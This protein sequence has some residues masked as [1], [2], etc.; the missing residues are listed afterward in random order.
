MARSAPRPE[1]TEFIDIETVG[2]S[3]P[4]C[5]HRTRAAYTCTRKVTMLDGVVQLCLHVRRCKH[6]KCPLKGRP[7]RPEAEGSFALPVHEFGLQVMAHVGALRYTQHRSVPEIHADLFERGVVISERSVTNL[8]DRYDE[9]LALQLGSDA[10][11]QEVTSKLG[12]VVLALDG[13]Q[14]DVGHEVLWVVR[15]ILS[16]EILR[17]RSL[18][19]ARQQDLAALLREVKDALR[20]PVVG[21]VSDGQHSIRKA[22][23]E[24]FPKVPYQLCQFHYLREAA[25]PIYEADRHAKKELK[26][27]V[28]GVRKLERSVEG[29]SDA[30]A[31]VVQGYC[32]AVRSALTD[33][34]RPPL[35]P[36]GLKLQERL[37]EV[38]ESLARAGKRG[39]SPRNSKA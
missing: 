18:L 11:L 16:G 32:A 22:V 39:A 10:H 30:Q 29:R 34:H 13:L 19:S 23:A 36:S 17:A 31:E 6:P 2:R 7:L 33:D 15:D 4:G 21:V 24:V 1:A 12:R 35:R 26:K 14:P 8:L 37:N 28:R 20:V 5:G 9:A 3:C 27:K 38:S 25:R